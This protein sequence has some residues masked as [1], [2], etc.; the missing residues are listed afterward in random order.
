MTH[1]DA[2]ALID[3]PWF[4]RLTAPTRWADLGCGSG[5]FTLALADLLAPGSS[6]EAVDLRPSIAPQ[7]TPRGVSI[8]PRAADFTTLDIILRAAA[9][10]RAVNS[11]SAHRATDPNS[12]AAADTASD[13]G[14]ATILPP[15]L[16]PGTQPLAYDGILMANSLHYVTD[17]RSFLNRLF[18]SPGSTQ[19]SSTHGTPARPGALLLVEY[20]T[21]VPVTRWV[22]YPLSFAAATRL[23]QSTHWPH[24]RKLGTQ[25][26]AFGRTE[27][28]AALALPE[29]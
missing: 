14:L 7:T 13:P 6:I 4:R 18:G 24:V 5:T 17:Q 8:H 19:H 3:T 28:Y 9:T 1:H 12:A 10:R 15:R 16:W 26:S 21:E 27:L 22:P 23:L 20:D 11:G 2:I 29:E 25:P